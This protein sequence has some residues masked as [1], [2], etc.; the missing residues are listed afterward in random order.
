MTAYINTGEAWVI[1][2]SAESV[3]ALNRLAKRG[4]D[5]KP[6]ESL[7]TGEEYRAWCLSRIERIAHADE[8]EA[9]RE[10]TIQWRSRV[11]SASEEELWA[12]YSH[13][14]P[15]VRVFLGPIKASS[16]RQAENSGE[17]S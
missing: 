9:E 11:E 14:P 17:K 3:R 12:E 13:N 6:P 4:R 1:Q 10:D 5:E 8:N 15:R 2:R 16:A 7:E